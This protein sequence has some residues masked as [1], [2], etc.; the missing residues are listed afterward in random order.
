MNEGISGQ[1]S[2][3]PRT[4]LDTL[5]LGRLPVQ[6]EEEEIIGNGMVFGAP[7]R[8]E[9]MVYDTGS[10]SIY[11]FIPQN[12]RVGGNLE[13]PPTLAI[14]DIASFLYGLRR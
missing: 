8:V 6:I 7:T 12:Y 11:S 14:P 3:A 5:L 1:F 13:G 9:D 2:S 10:D 4:F